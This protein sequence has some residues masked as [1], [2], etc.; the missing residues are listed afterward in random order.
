MVRFLPPPAQTA[1]DLSQSSAVIPAPTPVAS[2]PSAET[3]VTTDLHHGPWR[4][5]LSPL[6]T[7]LLLLPELLLLGA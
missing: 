3:C 1:I 5:R 6:D 7:N 4:N 2:M